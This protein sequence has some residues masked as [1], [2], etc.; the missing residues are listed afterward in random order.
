VGAELTEPLKSPYPWHGGKSRVADVV[1]RAFGDVPNY[2]EPFFGSGAVLLG[3]RVPG[4]IETINDLDCYVANFQRAIQ[5]D[6]GGVAEWADAQVNEAD[7]HARHLWL[8]NQ[9]DFRASMVAD[10]NFYDVKIAGWWVWGI[11]QWI[12]TGWCAAATSAARRRVDG[13]ASEDP[14]LDISKTVPQQIPHLGD[15]WMGVH[16]KIPHLGDA[17]RG[18]ESPRL[19]SLGHSGRGTHS[20]E[21]RPLYEWFSALSDRLRRVRVAC[22]DWSRIVTGA[23]LGLSN[24]R[25]NMGMTPC[26]VFLDPP[27]PDGAVDYNAGDRSTWH[28]VREWAIENGDNPCLRIALCGYEGIEMP[29]SWRVHAWKAKGGYGSQRKDGVNEN[30]NRERIWFSKHCRDVD[31]PDL[32]SRLG[33]ATR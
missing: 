26:G 3:R 14:A 29:A 16:R 21:H 1:W 31:Q 27:Y 9:Q 2:S 6:P 19:P 24:S 25:Q 30:P 17:G 8:V 11:C 18:P 32:F 22:G 4:K 20:P 12:G 7:L 15:A 28:E 33:G 13:C 23:V 10:P 5:A